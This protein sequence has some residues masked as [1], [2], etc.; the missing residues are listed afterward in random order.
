MRGREGAEEAEG[1][2][3]CEGVDEEGGEHCAGADGV[4]C[5]EEVKL[6]P[7]ISILFSI[8]PRKT[9]RRTMRKQTQS[10]EIVAII[11]A[12]PSQCQFDS[13]SIISVLF[14]NVPRKKEKKLTPSTPLS[15]GLPPSAP[16]SYSQLQALVPY[17]ARS[18]Y[19][20]SLRA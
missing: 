9:Y 10:R 2:V 14:F 16:I 18:S 1:D 17:K 12:P 5:A 20:A 15:P 6:F 7:L 8:V 4:E 3:G 19:T 13:I 11:T